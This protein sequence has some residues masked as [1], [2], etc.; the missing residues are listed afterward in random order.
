MSIGLKVQMFRIAVSTFQ[1]WN[2]SIF[3]LLIVKHHRLSRKHFKISRSHFFVSWS[4]FF[5]KTFFFFIYWRAQNIKK[6]K[7][8]D[9]CVKKGVNSNDLPIFLVLQKLN[10]KIKYYLFI[11]FA[12][13]LIVRNLVFAG[14][15][16]NFDQ[17][18]LVG[19]C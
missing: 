1:R 13:S 4:K 8:C 12:P 16:W 15:S 17:I 19:P 3:F 7:F 11:T 14:Y 6:W 18:V 10:E 5:L 9:V 2:I